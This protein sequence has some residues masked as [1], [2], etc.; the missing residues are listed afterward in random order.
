M[1]VLV[2]K[3]HVQR[4]QVDAVLAKLQ[5]MKPRVEADEPGCVFYQV[6][7]STEQEDLVLLYEHYVDEDALL[8]HRETV[9]FKEIIEGA[10]VPLLV[11]RERELYSLV[12]G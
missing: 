10:V 9:H 2:A 4:G 5:E 1:I 6:S 3:Y 11:E 12:I 7:R 8:G